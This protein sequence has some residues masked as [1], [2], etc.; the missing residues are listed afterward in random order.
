LTATV[1]IVVTTY[2]HARFLADALDSVM[3]QTTAVDEIIVVDDGSND[4]PEVVVGR[5]PDARLIRQENEGLSSARNTGLAATGSDYIAFLDADDMLMPRAIE[6]GLAAHAAK[7][8]CALVYGGHIFVDESG[9]QTGGPSYTPPGTSLFRKLLGINVI[10][11]H[12]SVL[13][14]RRILADAGGYDPTLRRCEDYDVYLTLARAHMVN[15][16]P[17][18]VAK[19]RYHSTNMSEDSTKMLSSALLVLDRHAVGLE[20]GDAEAAEA[21]RL[22]WRRYYAERTFRSGVMM[23]RRGRLSDATRLLSSSLRMSPG[24]IGSLV[25]AKIRR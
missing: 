6:A 22:G 3:A 15:S 11:M 7:P 19:Y 8:G 20:Q 10:G 25:A 13:Y 16:Y 23:L 14:D 9:K 21:G 18:A 2:N 24:A 17:E 12:G 1:T 4:H 5:Y